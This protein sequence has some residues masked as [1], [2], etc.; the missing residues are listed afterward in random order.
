[1]LLITCVNVANLMLARAARRRRE[2]ALRL[3]LGARR[4]R[5]ARQLLVEALLVFGLAAVGGLG[6]AALI[7][8]A[9]HSLGSDVLPRAAAIQLD[10]TVLLFALLLTAA[11]GLITGLLPALQG[12]AT[13]PRA[14]LNDGTRG[15]GGPRAERARAM[16]IVAEPG[17][18]PC[19]SWVPASCSAA[20]SVSMTSIRA[21]SRPVFSLSGLPC[22]PGRGR[23]PRPPSGISSR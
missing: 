16:L 5:V 12:S 19:C 21:S 2:I 9:A 7:V 1:V 20:C 4:G 8:R 15:T 10:G 18:P 17:S 11:T 14:A 3:A 6:L 22:R 23:S 13:T